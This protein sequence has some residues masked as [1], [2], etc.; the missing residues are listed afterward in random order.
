MGKGT[1]V[2]AKAKAVECTM[3]SECTELRRC[4]RGE[5]KR[6]ECHIRQ[7]FSVCLLTWRC[8]FDEV[9]G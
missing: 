1:G 6:H 3:C 9:K 8:R 5:E 4:W 7:A 2:T